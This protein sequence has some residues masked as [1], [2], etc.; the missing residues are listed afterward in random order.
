MYVYIMDELVQLE[1]NCYYIFFYK[2][3]VDVYGGECLSTHVSSLAAR[4]HACWGIEVRRVG[5][6]GIGTIFRREEDLE[7]DACWGNWV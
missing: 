3:A 1:Q 5:A 6:P 7:V 2:T 4:C